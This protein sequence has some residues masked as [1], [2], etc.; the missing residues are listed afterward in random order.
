MSAPTTDSVRQELFAAI[1]TVAETLADCADE[2]ERIGTYPERGWRALHEAGLFRLKAPREL[3]GWE[4]DPVTQIEVIERVARLDTSAAWTLFVG[5]GSLALSSAWL[6]E[7]GLEGFM[8]DGR[9]PRTAIGVAV[10]GSAVPVEGGYRLTARWPFASGCRHAEIVCGNSLIAGCDPPQV[11][12]F[13]FPVSAA[14]IHDTWNVTALQ[15]TGSADVEVV[16]LFVAA[17]ATFDIMAPAPRGGPLYTIALPGLVANEHGA[18]A[19]G[20]A[21]RALDE[22]AVLAKTKA[23]GYVVPEGVAGR[24]VFQADLGRADIALRAARAY[25][26]SANAAA[27]ELVLS[28]GSLD[29]AVQTELRT[30]AVY[31]TEA[32][33]DAV[34]S[35][36]RYAGGRALY[37]GN[38]VDRCLRDLQ[39]AAQHGMV[40]DASYE[41]RG[42]VLLGFPEV[43]A[44]S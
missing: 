44:F 1:D 19:L 30:A 8:V 10:S 22:V 9:L 40:N 29:A 24:S 39:G 2:A 27:W 15:G 41:A 20:V 28:G 16:D 7:A 25:L 36:Y 34:R 4:A 32:A 42:Q 14:T 37:T 33:L 38:V 3:G 13:T 18:F 21:R 35:V 23:R 11:R 12:S 5:A 43:A 26:I 31:A 17:D 6:P